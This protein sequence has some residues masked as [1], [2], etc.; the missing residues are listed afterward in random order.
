MNFSI[1]CRAGALAIVAVVV[2]ACASEADRAYSACIDQIEQSVAEI[3]EQGGAAAAPMIEM[4]RSMGTTAC[5]ALRTVCN[6]DPK[7][8]VCQG[9]S[10]EMNK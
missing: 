5:E 6:N 1:L 2:S 9:A 7:G 4:T 3:T 10:A 8:A